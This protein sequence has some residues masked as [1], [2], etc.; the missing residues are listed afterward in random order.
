MRGF[1]LPEFLNFLSYNRPMPDSSSQ[2]SLAVMVLS[3][4]F[5]S[6]HAQTALSYCQAAVDQGHRIYR[7]FFYHD[8]AYVASTLHCVPQ[9]EIDVAKQWQAFIQQ[10][11]ID[12]VVCIASAL[13]RGIIDA[14]EAKRYEKNAHNLA[15]GFELSGLGQWVDAVNSADQ[16]IVFGR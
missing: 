15:A 6:Q 10:H 11:E 12:A 5:S 9:D 2:K 8:G 3:S 4:P 16:H 1:L 13:K 7:V 14:T